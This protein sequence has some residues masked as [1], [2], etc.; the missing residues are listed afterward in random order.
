MNDSPST[1]FA[2]SL[3][4]GEIRE[5]MV[6]P[7][8]RLGPAEQG[9]VRRLLHR[10]QELARDTI[11]PRR[12]DAEGRIPAAVLDGLRALGFFGLSLPPAYGGAGLST[13]ATCR[14]LQ[15]VAAAD[16]SLA[17]M[18]IAHLSLCAA[19]I[20]HFGSEAQ[21]QRYLPRLASG[22]ALGAFAQTETQS[23]SD[24]AAIRTRAFPQPGGGWLLQGSKLWVTNGALA[25]VFVL[26]AQTEVRR[27]GAQ[28]DRI[29]G[30][31]AE[32]GPGLRHGAEEPKLGVR[33]CST[34]ALY[35][36]DLELPAEAVLGTVGGGF[37]VAMETISGAHLALA[38]AWVGMAREVLRLAVQHATSRR[39]FGRLLSTFGMI[40]DKLARMQIDVYAAESM[41]YLTSGLLD[42][43]R[44]PVD[45]SLESACC[46]VF[47]SETLWRVVH[48][49]ACIAGG[50]SL[51]RDYPYERLLRDSRV[52]LFFGGTNEVLRCYIALTGMQGPGEQL[53]R[54]A[55]AI[56]HPLRGYGL[57]VDTLLGQVRS[58]AYGG[59]VLSLHHGR[60]KKEAV[61]IEDSVEALQKGVDRVLRRHGR[62]ISEMQYVQQRVADVAID[63]YA[64][65]ACVSRCTAALHAHDARRAAG[66]GVEAA[67]EIDEAERELRLCHG[68]CGKAAERIRHRLE[69][70]NQ[71]DDE[72]MK[73]IAADSYH[74][75]T[76]PLDAPFD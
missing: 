13:T 42:Q 33:A 76:Y 27:H 48:E 74:G 38:A 2:R 68:F 26:L 8:P 43:R 10:F 15:E 62:Q 69:R 72:L 56:K 64:M 70:F 47:A 32:R 49:A 66:E 46:K 9:V 3:F 23:G 4:F 19:A 31:V 24:A 54:L 73:A 28:A 22:T 50:A 51:M 30:F 71:N 21:K 55:E 35:L 20:V 36:D 1:S 29:T 34:T 52:G 16:A 63:L 59:P 25:D 57:V 18:L 7:Y 11:D 5:E 60:L 12:M 61:A 40:R 14:L 45:V 39:Q 6:F 67:G 65:V 58:A 17:T 41:L 75:R 37:K 44:R 53:A